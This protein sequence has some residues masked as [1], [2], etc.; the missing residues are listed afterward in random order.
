MEADF[1]KTAIVRWDRIL[2]RRNIKARIV[3][4]IHDAIGVEAQK[5]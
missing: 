2:R 4:V 1:I 3:M 5:Q